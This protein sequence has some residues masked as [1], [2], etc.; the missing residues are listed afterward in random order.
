MLSWETTGK[1]I[2]ILN[3]VLNPASNSLAPGV[4]Q[5]ECEN[6]DKEKNFKEA[7]KAELLKDNG[8][9]NDKHNI[10][11]EGHKQERKDVEAKRI[12]H[13]GRANGSFTRLI[14]LKFFL[15]PVLWRKQAG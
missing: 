4:C 2:L 7:K 14:G 10:H 13:P 1:K 15:R 12:L 6:K 11:I 3:M 8:P 5:A 9:G